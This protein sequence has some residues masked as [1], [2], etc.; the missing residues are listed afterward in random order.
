SPLGPDM[1]A[2]NL[3]RLKSIPNVRLLGPKAFQELPAYVKFFDACMVLMDVDR[4]NQAA[5]T[6]SRTL[7]KWLLYLAQGKPV[8][9][10]HWKEAEPFADLVRLARSDKDFADLLKD[11]LSEPTDDPVREARMEYA[12]KFSF[13]NTLDRIVAPIVE[14]ERASRSRPVS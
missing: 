8:V 10:P 9:A 13:A 5:G 6:R 11:A 12:A 1:S 7:F 14:F 3:R 2:E 4:W